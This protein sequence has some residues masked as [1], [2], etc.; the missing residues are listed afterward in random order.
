MRTLPVT[1]ALLCAAA[2]SACGTTADGA[3][4]SST[5]EPPA[6]S[7]AAAPEDA[8]W[9]RT[10]L[11][12]SV[13]GSTIPG[14][15]PLEVAFPERGHIA[16]SAGCN[17]GVS[18]VDLA[19]GTVK[20]G[21]IATTMMAC[22]GDLAGA[23]E[24]MTDLFA[25]EPSWTLAEDTLTLASESITVTLADKKTTEPVRP[26]IGTTW[27]VESL[28]K[29]DAIVT[30]AALETSAPSLTIGQDG[31]ATGS[32]GCNRFSGPVRVGDSTITFGKLATTR[33]A[34]PDDVADVERAVLHVLD[35]EVTYTVEGPT[36]TLMQADGTGLQLRGN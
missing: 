35:G 25:A 16:M 3:D 33:V 24:W 20:T 4:A 26:V 5:A 1:L 6:V 29:P 32:T 23:D 21:P 14:S 31:Q 11:S 8:L 10:F 9:G 22:P 13:T 36:M 19:G 15:G 7:T 28:I 30:S 17:R 18:S 34:C 12:T 2:L 27:V